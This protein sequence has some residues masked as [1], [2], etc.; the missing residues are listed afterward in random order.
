MS[1]EGLMIFTGNANPKLAAD[2]SAHLH[3]P[4]G[5]ATV[6]RFSDGGYETPHQVTLT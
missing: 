4:L 2:V 1:P 5:K 3:L 6:G